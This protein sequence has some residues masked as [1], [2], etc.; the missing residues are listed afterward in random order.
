MEILENGKLFRRLDS[1]TIFYPTILSILSG[2]NSNLTLYKSF[3]FSLQLEFTFS[4]KELLCTQL[5][6]HIGIYL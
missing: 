6:G 1:P 4:N 3:P 2:E 5:E